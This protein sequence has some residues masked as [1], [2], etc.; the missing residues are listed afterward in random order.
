MF[1]DDVFIYTS[2]SLIILIPHGILDISLHAHFTNL[3]RFSGARETLLVDTLCLVGFMNNIVLEEQKHNKL[4][5]A[6][7]CATII[8]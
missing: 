3:K 6:V 8:A 2:F 1:K 4:A 7:L 5:A